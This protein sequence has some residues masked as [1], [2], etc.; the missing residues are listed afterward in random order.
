MYDVISCVPLRDSTFSTGDVQ[1]WSTA[2]NSAFADASYDFL[3]PD[4]MYDIAKNHVTSQLIGVYVKLL[5]G[6]SL[7]DG[8][9]E[10]V[11]IVKLVDVSLLKTVIQGYLSKVISTAARQTQLD[12]LTG[13]LFT[14]TTG[15]IQNIAGTVQVQTQNASLQTQ[16]LQ[17][18]TLSQQQNDENLD[19]ILS[20]VSQ[21][22]LGSVLH[23][24]KVISNVSRE[25]TDISSPDIVAKKLFT[26]KLFDRVFNLVVD[27]D[28]FEID[29]DKTNATPQGTQALQQLLAN[30]DITQSAN[31]VVTVSGGIARANVNSYSFRQRDK[32]EGDYAL[33]KYFV[34]IETVG[35]V[36]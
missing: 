25:L 12:I 8:D 2:R 29:A 4:Q 31:V 11:D 1:Y 6:L 18:K 24:L 23:G 14:T 15:N 22:V 13:T 7:S 26:P 36:I 9:F 21:G 32:N 34:S 35:D 17:Q 33:E 5:T 19:T 3:T 27:P 20:Q 30:G 16:T 28:D 10:T